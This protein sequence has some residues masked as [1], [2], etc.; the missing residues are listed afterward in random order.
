MGGQEA[1]GTSMASSSATKAQ[2]SLPSVSRKRRERS[3][4]DRVDPILESSR[5]ETDCTDERV[6]R[7]RMRSVSQERD[8]RRKRSSRSNA[9]R[10][11]EYYKPERDERHQPTF[12]S[13]NSANAVPPQD[14]TS[15]QLISTLTQ[16]LT[17]NATL[18]SQN[19]LLSSQVQTLIENSRPQVVQQQPVQDNAL[20]TTMLILQ[21]V[22]G[23]V[24]QA[25]N[26]RVSALVNTPAIQ[27]IVSRVLIFGMI[28]F[29]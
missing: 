13:T 4:S 23:T 8:E 5:S 15:Q 28:D 16:V 22:H 21:G 12:S 26:E 25:V 2:L 18:R 19:A 20:Q 11:D 29:D 3:P 14:Y 27:A 9:D 1:A 6:S 10:N 7:R 17:D 24:Q